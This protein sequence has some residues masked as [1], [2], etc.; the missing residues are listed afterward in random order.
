M[1][2]VSQ[3]TIP[4]LMTIGHLTENRIELDVANSGQ[5]TDKLMMKELTMMLDPIEKH[6]WFAVRYGK[7]RLFTDT[8]P[9]SETV[10]YHRHLTNAVKRYNS[11]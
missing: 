5:G 10:G 8:L 6:M 3:H 4:G 9:L 1:I 2:T 11:L 7:H